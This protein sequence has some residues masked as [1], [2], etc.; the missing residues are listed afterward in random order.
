MVLDSCVGQFMGDT[1]KIKER[2]LF[3]KL[4]NT[5][6]AL[7]GVVLLLAGTGL[8]LRKA[9]KLLASATHKSES[10]LQEFVVVDFGL[11]NTIEDLA[12]YLRQFF[13]TDS[14]PAGTLS[15]IMGTF[16]S[17]LTQCNE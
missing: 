17:F 12:E 8:R 13:P 9:M 16:F 7:D 4:V 2:P 15:N 1:H 3:S 14:I 6:A 5:W 11:Y 10:D